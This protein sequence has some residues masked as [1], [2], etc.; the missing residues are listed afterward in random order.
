MSPAAVYVHHR[1][2]EALLFELSREGHQAVLDALQVAATEH[3]TPTDQLRAQITA[4]V[5]RHAEHHTTAR[6]V[7]YEFV[8]LNDEH[9]SEIEE[10][11]RAIRNEVAVVLEAGVEAGEFDCD[12]IDLTLNAITG[13]GVDVAR[14]YQGDGPWTPH[15]IATHQAGL[16]LRLVNA[17]VG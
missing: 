16:A 13:M 10:L 8:G 11:R 5:Q 14:W 6:I 15:E 3:S 12:N 2:K 4:F 1:T 17:N 7:N 9:Q